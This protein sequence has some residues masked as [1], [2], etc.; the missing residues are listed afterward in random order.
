VPF[1]DRPA[2]PALLGALA[3]AEV[4]DDPWPAVT[5]WLR[6]HTGAELAE[7]ARPLGVAAGPVRHREMPPPLVEPSAARSPAGSLVVDFS[8]LWAGPLCAHL[9]GLAGARVVKVETPWRPDGARFGD[10][11]F[12]RL[13]HAGHRSVVLDP[14]TPGGRHSPGLARRPPGPRRRMDRRHTVR[15][16]P[17]GIPRT[18]ACAG[19]PRRARRAH[20][21][22]PARTENPHT[23][24][25]P[26]AHGDHP[27][28]T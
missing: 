25:V 7:R 5:A 24:T 9:L 6:G 22:G 13:L 11:G 20:H 1:D 23:V 28:R 19:T 2:D 26:S 15:P 3:C 18:A 17:G 14:H 12:Y 16:D 10:A 21:R 4:G 27:H 8:A